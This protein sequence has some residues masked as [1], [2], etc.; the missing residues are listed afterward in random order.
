MLVFLTCH[1]SFKTHLGVKRQ[2]HKLQSQM[3]RH[4]EGKPLPAERNST[5]QEILTNH[6]MS[7]RSAVPT[8]LN[9]NFEFKTLLG[10]V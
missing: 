6:K 5:K 7:S 8:V 3:A 1:G 10:L 4:Q 2:Q 9:L